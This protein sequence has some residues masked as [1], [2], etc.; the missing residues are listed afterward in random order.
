MFLEKVI[1]F[2]LSILKKVNIQDN[3]N[4]VNQRCNIGEES[5]LGSGKQKHLILS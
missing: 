2:S 3:G 4:R 1:E 5:V